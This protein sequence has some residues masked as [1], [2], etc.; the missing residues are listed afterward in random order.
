MDLYTDIEY[1]TILGERIK[2]QRLALNIS[3]QELAEFCGISR[4][5]IILLEKGKGIHLLYL[6]RVL[7]KLNIDMNLLDLIP[8]TSQIDPFEM[9]SN[10][11][12][13]RAS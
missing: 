1:L 12:R 9:P 6:V 7:R 3:Q 4:H 13:E 8:K 11:K 2:E 5:T 10:K